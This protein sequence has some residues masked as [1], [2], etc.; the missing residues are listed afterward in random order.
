MLLLTIFLALAAALVFGLNMH[1]QDKGLD[2][3]DELT[4]SFLSVVTM[5]VVFWM[6]SPAFIEL[7]WFW[8]GA[9]WLF[10]LSGV[11]VPALGQRLQIASVALVGPSVASA[12]NGF[13]PLFSVLPAVLF[14]GERFGLQATI[15]LSIMIG[16]V[17]F[18]TLFK[19]KIRRSWPIWVLIIPL[20][21]AFVRG[22]SPVINKSGYAEVNS[23]FFATLVMSTV[24][25]LILGSI[26]AMRRKPA[27]KAGSRTGYAWFAASG[28]LNG[29]GILCINLA[30]SFGDISIVAPLLM[31]SPIW[32]LLFSVFVFKRE[33]IGWN[34][35][36]LAAAIVGG[37]VL[38]ILR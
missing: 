19:G 33:V 29:I 34:H 35:V 25:T 21:A 38:I 5:A 37:S 2:D 31:S 10:A 22:I 9:F 20:T 15:G 24:S 13:L 32:A 8:K 30:I 16:G 4:G 27:K 6:L 12:V 1:I 3:T 23:P 14:L 7:S 26:L 11:V 18:T 36:L 28:L 17:L